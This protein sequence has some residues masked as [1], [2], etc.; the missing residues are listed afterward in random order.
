MS[1]KTSEFDRYERLR[2]LEREAEAEKR[3]LVET[4]KKKAAKVHEKDESFSFC[5]LRNLDF[6]DFED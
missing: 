3:K 6:D 1:K 5:R 2:R 4:P